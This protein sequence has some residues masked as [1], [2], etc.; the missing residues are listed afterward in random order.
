MDLIQ[1]IIDSKQSEEKLAAKSGLPVD[2]IKAILN[3][4]EPS[5]ID[6]KKISKALKLS[7]DFFLSNEKKDS[8]IKLLFRKSFYDSNAIKADRFS[9]MVA[10]SFSLLSGQHYNYS[11]INSY[12]SFTENSYEN[13]EKLA[14]KFRIDFFKSDFY[15]PLLNLPQIVDEKLNCI[16]YISE[17]GHEIDGASAII[18]EVPYIFI[19]PRFEPRMLYTLAHELGHILAHHK[20]DENFVKFDKHISL[21]DRKADEAFCNAFASSLLLPIEGLAATIQKLRDHFKNSGSIGDIEIL[22]LSRIYGVS[23][24]VAAR[25]CEDLDLLPVGGANSLYQE[26]K[27]TYGSPE[28]RAN[29]VGIPPRFEITFPQVSSKLIN[30]A[31]EKINKGEMSLGKVSEM[32]SLPIPVILSKNAARIR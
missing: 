10:N 3:G 28:K 23:F 18:N 12:S 16:L 24:E 4:E 5:L 32:L 6:L 1:Y 29:E 13:A 14:Q 27:K 20:T 8:E 19:S 9:H 15:S 11:W 21:R 25:R 7:I 26:I 31:L 30:A 22:Y 2:R 17:F